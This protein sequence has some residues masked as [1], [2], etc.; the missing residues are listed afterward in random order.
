MFIIHIG[1]KFFASGSYAI[2]YIYANELFPTQGRNTG[3][4][5]CSMVA[6]FGAIIGTLSNDL[7]VTKTFSLRNNLFVSVGSC[8]D[9]S[10][11]CL[12]R[13]LVVGRGRLRD[14]LPRNSEYTTPSNRRG[15]RKDGSCPVCVL[16]Q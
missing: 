10:S 5:I 11:H 9:P 14:D 7:L 2:I 16:L 4:G 3:M 8:V 6:R 15:C 12:L 1:L 13:Y